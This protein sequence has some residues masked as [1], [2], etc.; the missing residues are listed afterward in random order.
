MRT[1]VTSEQLLAALQSGVAPESLDAESIT[2]PVVTEAPAEPALAA[3]VVVEEPAKPTLEAP[4]VSD[5][6]V[7]YLKTEVSSLKADVSAKDA[8]IA[9]LQAEVV[10]LKASSSPRLLDIVRT[11]CTRQAIALNSA[12]IGVEKLQGE[13][14]A[15]QWV[16][17][18][19]AIVAKFKVGA[20][21][22]ASADA[23][24]KPVPVAAISGPR[25]GKTFKLS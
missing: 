8:K 1:Q 13:A 20:Q 3:P 4:K 17:L 25:A 21:S 11:A 10:S 7:T 15:D 5:D 22:R 18:D 9:E 23:V 16:A 24:V 12:L 6:F 19:E 14:L 2:P